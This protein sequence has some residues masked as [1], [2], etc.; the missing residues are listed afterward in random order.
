[1]GLSLGDLVV[2]SSVQPLYPGLKAMRTLTMN[3][4]DPLFLSLQWLTRLPVNRAVALPLAR[5]VWAFPLVG[6]LLGILQAM[7]A[8]VALWAGLPPSVIAGL[9]LTTSAIITGALHEDG[10]ADTADGLWGGQSRDRRLD[11]MRDSRIGSY[12]VIAL[13]LSFGLRWAALT[14][15]IS[16]GAVWAPLI[17][18]GAISRAAM[19]PMMTLP[20]ARDN[21]LGHGAGQPQRRMTAITLAIALGIAIVLTGS[22]F[23]M[24]ILATTTLSFALARLALRKIGGQTGDILG[25]TQQICEITVLLA[26]L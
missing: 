24:I 18:A 13:I 9:V 1:M 17:V 15:L 26:L 8:M 20:P 2:E 6:L 4:L 22:D 12:G 16:A 23:V 14:T 3:F 19:V 10:L 25:A 5:A 7:V 11:I 21:G